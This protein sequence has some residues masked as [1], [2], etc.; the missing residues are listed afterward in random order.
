MGAAG[1]RRA[2]DEFTWDAVAKKTVRVYEQVIG[3]F[4]AA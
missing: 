1:R 2:L 3:S 4:R